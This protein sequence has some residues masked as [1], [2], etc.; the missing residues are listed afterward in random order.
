[1]SRVFACTLVWVTDMHKRFRC[2]DGIVARWWESPARKASERE[3]V[4]SAR[5]GAKPKKHPLFALDTSLELTKKTHLFG[6]I[7]RQECR[8]D[9][10]YIDI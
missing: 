6:R 2:A 1:M 4:S 9:T 8:Q 7:Q 3:D 5:S 10:E